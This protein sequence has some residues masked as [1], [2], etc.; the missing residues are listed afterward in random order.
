MESLEPRARNGPDDKDEK[1][2]KLPDNYTPDRKRKREDEP[3]TSEAIDWPRLEK[4]LEKFVGAESAEQV[5][6]FLAKFE[7]GD[8]ERRNEDVST[9]IMEQQQEQQ[10]VKLPPV[11]EKDKRRDLH[12]WIRANLESCG[13]ADTIDENGDKVIRIWHV[14]FEKNMPNYQKFGQSRNRQR[15]LAPSGKNYLQFVLYKENM[16]TG[17]A[18]H[19]IQ[20]RLSGKHNKKLRIGY[21]GNKDK[22][23]ITCQFVTVPAT[24]SIS[25]L[26]SWNNHSGQGGGHTKNAGASVIRL[27]NFEYAT[28][29]LRL[30]RLQ[31]N[32]FDV[33]LRNIQINE[34][35]DHDATKAHLE[36]AANAIREHGFINY[37]GVQRFGKYHD[38]HLTGVAVLNGDFEKAI[39]IIM[40]IKEDERENVMK[41]RK[42][43]EERFSSCCKERSKAEKEC[44]SKLSREFH[45]SMTAEVAILQ[46]LSRFPLDYKR[47]FSCIPKTLRMMFIH[48]VQSYVWNS[49]ASHR[50]QIGDG[51]VLVGDLIVLDKTVQVGSK[52]LSPVKALTEEDVASG[53]YSLED[54]VLPLIGTKTQSPENECGKLMNSL[55]NKLGVTVEMMRKVED[56]D[57]LCVGDYRNIIC[58][59][60]D[61]D[62]SIVEYADPFQPLLQTDLMKLNNIPVETAHQE[63]KTDKD[64]LLLGMVVGFSLPSSS[65]ATIFMRELM[66]RPTSSEFQRD[67]KLGAT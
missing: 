53:K 6:A 1:D 66:K 15:Q 64:S 40:G 3:A 60:K 30:G 43:W 21:A 54:I 42:L 34:G 51:K 35:T 14:S 62:F 25:T 49:A 24:T 18:I 31:G 36:R 20:R 61:V 9:T 19:Q 32:R 45:R 27:G 29:E 26:C 52:S 2:E 65:Y 67:L 46:C 44:A 63:D 58:H 8:N 13:R 23:G 28:E 38:S 7:K 57:M 56:R 10:F 12:Q 5:I 33:V 50:V 55:L 39:S 48:A 17:A 41:A 37:F 22:R 4:E 11:K 59:P 47:A 16:D